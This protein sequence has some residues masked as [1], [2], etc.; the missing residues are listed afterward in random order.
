MSFT[1]VLIDIE[2]NNLL[3]PLMDFSAMPYKLKD[4]A[5]LWCISLRDLNN[6]KNVITFSNEECTRENLQDA[7]KN[8]IVLA[9]HNIVNFDL[10]MLQLFGVLDYSVGYIGEYSTLYGQPLKTIHDTIVWSKLLEPDRF[11]GHSLKNLTKSYG[12]SSKSHFEDFSQWSQEMVDYCEQDTLANTELY[13]EQLEAISKWDYRDSYEAELK[14]V[15]LVLKQSL[16]GFA[17]N[18]DLA[19]QHLKTFDEKLAFH[20]NNVDH[21]LPP[22]KMTKGDQ[23]AYTPPAI[24]FKKDGSTSSNL[25]KFATKLGAVIDEEENTFTFNGKVYTLPLPKDEPLV[26]EEVASIKDLAHLKSYLLQCGWVPF[27][28]GV[29]DITCKSGSKIKYSTKEEQLKAIQTYVKSTLEG[30]FREQRLK[31]IGCDAIDLEDFLIAKCQKEKSVKLPTTPSLKVGQEKTICPDLQR[32]GESATFVKDVLSYFMWRHRRTCIAGSDTVNE[33][34]DDEPVTGYLSLIRENGRIPTNADTLGSSTYRMKHRGIANLPRISS[35]G[36]QELREL[37]GPGKGFIQIGGDLASVEACLQGHYVYQYVNGPELAATLIA[38]KPNDLHAFPVSSQ[39]LTKSGWK[40]FDEI[41]LSTE[42]AQ[43]DEVLNKINFTLPN[44][45]LLRNNNKDDLMYEFTGAFNFKMTTT[46]K[47]RILLCNQDSSEYITVLA[48]DLDKKKYSN[49]YIP[50]SANLI[51]TESLDVSDNFLKLLVATQADGHLN[52]DSSAISFTF[53][54][55]RKIVRLTDL[56]TAE[57]VPYT[58][59]RYNRKGRDEITI[60]LNAG[61]FTKSLRNFLTDKKQFTYDLLRLSSIQRFVFLNEIQYWDGTVTTYGTTIL[62]TTDHVSAEIVNTLLRLSNLN[63]R[64]YQY[65]RKTNFGD[66]NITRIV[67]SQR[68]PKVKIKDLNIRTYYSEEKVGCVTVP[69]SYLLVKQENSIFLSGNC[70][71]TDTEILTKQGF[72]FADKITLQSNVAQWHKSNQSIT[73]TYPSEVIT[74]EYEGDMVSVE[75]DRL[76]I[77]M[78]PEHRNIVLRESGQYVDILA[79]DLKT[80]D[81]TIPAYGLLNNNNSIYQQYL[82]QYILDEFSNKAPDLENPMMF[83]TRLDPGE[84]ITRKRTCFV[85]RSPNKA[86]IEK[87]IQTL[88]TYD[89]QALL[90]EKQI[91]LTARSEFITCYQTI[92]P[93]TTKNLK[94]SS[95]AHTDIKVVPYKGTVHCIT[96]SSSYIICRRNGKIFVTGNSLNAKKLNISR[97]SAKSIS[98]AIM[99]GS[100]PK[101]LMSMLGITLAEAETLYKNYW[102]AVLP[103][104]H[105]KEDVEKY[106]KK[107]AN[108]YVSGMD[109]RKLNARSSHSLV[110]LL[111]QSAGAISFKHAVLNMCQELEEL[112]YLGNPLIHKESDLKAY[113]MICYHK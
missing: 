16:F 47:H 50:F 77:L 20:Q 7:L 21:L 38:K 75:G 11:G 113:L 12:S 46:C 95:L 32:L 72:V 5:R 23:D 9:G 73:Y 85:L 65:T 105:F 71:A 22:K 94:G 98:Y 88:A 37:L 66:C 53:V 93:F 78:T 42:V 35:P 34:D 80:T 82:V 2:T 44:S 81:G 49:Y 45:I 52:L 13:H 111:F 51:E 58:V 27:E 89:I 19:Y 101:K 102:E 69:S 4:E 83:T 26:T 110:N 100:S 68:S 64:S 33:F 96:V 6:P 91:K 39:L 76:S 62:D 103:L 43:W 3:E 24:Q 29:R 56:L 8:T 55:E 1:H 10:P 109:G 41:T 84:L 31:I 108:K 70:L 63:S 112:G 30:L 57:S 60:R 67:F 86:K 36:G 107:T 97:D 15:D 106:Y 74:S 99:Y 79:K 61:E 92:L 59:S 40:T 54:K 104:K 18:K 87:I 28:W 48:K 14:I 17:F 90:V 25:I